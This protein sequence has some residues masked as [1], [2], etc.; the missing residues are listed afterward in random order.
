MARSA[1]CCVTLAFGLAL[2]APLPASAQAAW[3]VLE[4]P[5]GVFSVE[6]PGTPGYKLE[7][8]KSGGG[9][10]F[11]YHSYSLDYQGRAY[12]AQTATY[13]ADVDVSDPRVNLQNALAA[14]V[15]GMQ[16]KKWDQVT[17][18]T[19]QGARAVEATGKL[20]DQL[21]YRN[22]MVLKGRQMYS[23]GYAGPPGTI[24]DP[25]ANRYFESLRLK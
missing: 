15:K 25:D 13:P 4:G 9:T 10:L 7:Q 19:V 17:W 5:S 20:S 18:T 11:A 2:L 22:L 21:E 16:S 12:V 24:R 14:S 6:M 3:Q 1:A 8:A 23:F